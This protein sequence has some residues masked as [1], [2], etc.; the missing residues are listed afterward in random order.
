M[1]RGEPLRWHRAGTSRGLS[2]VQR[3]S[4]WETIPLKAHDHD[5]IIYRRA[6]LAF[7]VFPSELFLPENVSSGLEVG[8]RPNP[9]LKNTSN[10]PNH[11]TGTQRYRSGFIRAAALRETSGGCHH[12]GR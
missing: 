4:T 5:L 6:I 12:P 3:R 1:G 10:G 11:S 2:Q 8:L 9:G 7:Q